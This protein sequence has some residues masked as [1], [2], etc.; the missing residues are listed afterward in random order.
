MFIHGKTHVR[1]W[2][3]CVS[4]YMNNWACQQVHGSLPWEHGC[5]LPSCAWLQLIQWDETMIK[6]MHAL[7]L[8][9][10]KSCFNTIKRLGF[11]QW[12]TNLSPMTH[13]CCHTMFTTH[14]VSERS[15]GRNRHRAPLVYICGYMK[16]QVLFFYQKHGL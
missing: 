10:Y 14:V 4:S 5:T 15:C 12:P 6:Q 13:S 8:S 2:F 9:Q 11:W 7:G 1:W 16:I 3:F